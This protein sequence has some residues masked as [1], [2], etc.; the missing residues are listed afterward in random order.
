MCAPVF[1]KPE[2]GSHHAN[3]EL[4]DTRVGIFI[5]LVRIRVTV[6]KNV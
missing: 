3:L 5:I 2:L 6:T 4:Y 1:S